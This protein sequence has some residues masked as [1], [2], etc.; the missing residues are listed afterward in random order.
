[1]CVVSIAPTPILVSH[2]YGLT[3]RP[4]YILSAT[5]LRFRSQWK[6]IPYRWEKISALQRIVSRTQ[7][8]YTEE[9][10]AA[11]IQGTGR[12]MVVID[13]TG[14][15]VN[16]SSF[17]MVGYGLD[18]CANGCAFGMALQTSHQGWQ[19]CDGMGIRQRSF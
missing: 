19:A 9:A 12:Y 13:P 2:V 15:V 8:E 4:N 7:P 11:R 16:T 6:R 3:G 17:S 5:P 14:R 18:A 1:M 10:G